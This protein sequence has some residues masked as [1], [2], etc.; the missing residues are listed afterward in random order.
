MNYVQ[1]G[2]LGALGALAIPIAIHL[3]FRRQAR[4]LDLGTIRFLKI[5]LRE[6]TR[7]RRLKRY[8][9]LAMR[10]SAVALLALLFARPYLLANEPIDGRRL[11]VVL[12][13][14]S[15][16]MGMTGGPRPIDRAREELRRILGTGGTGTRFE[17][18]A[19]D[20]VIAPFSREA[21]AP[22][23]P[24]ATGTDYD[25]ALAWARD[26]LVRSDVPTKEL[27]ILTDLQRS[28]LDRGQSPRLPG[29]VTVD[30]IDLGRAFPRNAG[31]IGVQVS[32]GSPSPGEP[33]LVIATLRNPSPMPFAKLAATLHLEAQGA[34][35]ID[36]DALIDL[37]GG[38]TATLEFSLPELA[39]GLWTGYVEIGAGDD[40]A[41]DDRRHLAISV[42]S[43]TR[44][45][46]VDG[47]PG[48]SPFE[49][50]TFF[51]RAAL[52]LAPEG[53]TYKKAVFDAST[54]DATELGR[55]LPDLSGTSAVVLANVGDL[56]EAIAKE[57]AEYVRG[58]G[59]L[60]VFT[61][62]RVTGESSASL[63]AEGLTP[64][65][66]LGPSAEGDGPFRL[67]IWDE[68]HPIFSPFADPESGDLRRPSFAT[69]TKIEPRTGASV[70]ARFRG[71]DPAM[72]EATMG[73]G[74]IAWFASACDRSW[75]DW[76]RGRLYLPMIHQIVSRAAGI[77]E[78]G[79]VRSEVA[80]ADRPPGVTVEA[81]LAFVVNLDPLE[82]ETARCSPREFADRYGFP[83]PLPNSATSEDGSRP[84]R[85]DDRLRSDE[86][87][88]W[89]ALGLAGVLMGEA[90]LANRT[91]G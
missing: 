42:A 75:G 30:L 23:G 78:A 55:G 87:W 20:R 52:Q 13:D 85:G 32:P 63:A 57:L 8:A 36:R 34:D 73:R 9:L 40:L 6:N 53:E 4:S 79:P 74:R 91:S 18:A 71:N 45:L 88:P 49:S 64:G 29:D 37:E 12:V 67:G 28:G 58:G 56:P 3:M 80:S 70:L 50:E 5:V 48:R 84:S 60:V 19:F 15:A 31:V 17:M 69:I 2:M 62:D 24:T 35:S 22:S 10:L 72:I 54:L 41:A 82:T 1:A 44:I 38:A 68:T 86:F 16:S 14:R 61:G 90:F 46:L 33:A 89:L 81:G 76:P 47:D 39:E 7:R 25:A 51:L 43:P 83:L 27:H 11:V 21:E 77:T 59:G 66:I 26:V 65:E